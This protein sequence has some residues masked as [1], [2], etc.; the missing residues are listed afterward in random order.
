MILF[1]KS[2]RN[3]RA[4]PPWS[5]R[6]GNQTKGAWGVP[7]ADLPP[8]GRAVRWPPRH[9][10]SHAREGRYNGE[11]FLKCFPAAVWARGMWITSKKPKGDYRSSCCRTCLVNNVWSHRAVRLVLIIIFWWPWSIT[12]ESA[13]QPRAGPISSSAPS[14]SHLSGTRIHTL[15]HMA[16]GVVG[17]W[18]A[19][20]VFCKHSRAAWLWQKSSSRLFFWSTLRSPLFKIEIFPWIWNIITLNKSVCIMPFVFGI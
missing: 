15:T 12:L 4:E 3:P 5:Q 20:R 10:R 11:H 18:M 14:Q 19:G 16:R 6:A 13:E 7:P 9:P 1:W 2:N 8:G 17:R